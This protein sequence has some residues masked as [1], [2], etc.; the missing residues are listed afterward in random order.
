MI[1]ENRIRQIWEDIKDSFRAEITDSIVDLWFGKVQVALVTDATI[2]MVVESDV[3]K[4]VLEAKYRKEIESRFA[5]AC[6]QPYHVQFVLA[7]SF[8][9]S[10]AKYPVYENPADDPNAGLEDEI[11]RNP[12]ITMSKVV[13]P[14]PAYVKIEGAAEDEP[15][16]IPRPRPKPDPTPLGSTMPPFNFEYTF[17]NFI[18]GSSN[19]FAH[20]ACLAVADRPAQEY[21]PLFIYGPSG[22]G[23]TH[24]LYAITNALKQKKENINVIYIKGEDFT[25]QLIESLSRQAMREFRAKYRSCDV[26]LID[27][28]Q[29]I[30]GKMSTQEE[31]FHTFNALHEDGKQIILTS[32][33]PPREIKTLEDRLKTRFEWGLIADIQPPDLE[34]RTAIIKKKA[35]QVHLTLPDNV[36]TF[37]AENLRSN[38]RQIEGAIKKLGAK[39]FLSGQEITMELARSCI[40]ELLGDAEPVHVTVDRIFEVVFKKWNVPK[41]DLVGAKRTKEIAAARHIAVYLIHEVTDM[42]L[43][44]IGRIFYR[45]HTTVMSSIDNVERKMLQNPIFQAEIEETIKEIQGL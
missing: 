3:K 6:G 13:Q 32:D 16:Y 26:L 28:I 34:L 19:K 29:F 12:G 27:D 20:A 36:M 24:L 44:N 40:A 30:A 9:D 37:L 18:V 15:Q 11:L 8:D 31:F 33:R 7:E 14:H 39:S 42:S 22:L 25:N 45:D 43:P 17:E 23:K 10:M 5:A 4:R 35:E 1:D 38:I 2:L 41:E 21:N